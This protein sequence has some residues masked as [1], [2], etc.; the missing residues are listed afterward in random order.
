[1]PSTMYGLSNHC[2][3]QHLV[4]VYLQHSAQY[5][6]VKKSSLQHSVSLYLVCAA[7]GDW[8]PGISGDH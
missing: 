2:M 5:V 3:L 7:N 1:M 4:F 6:Y 8:A